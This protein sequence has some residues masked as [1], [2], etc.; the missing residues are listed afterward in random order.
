MHSSIRGARP[1]GFTLIELLVVIAIIGVLISLLVPAVQKV[2]WAAA[3]TQCR[4]NLHNLGLA[5]T[6]YKDING[7][8]YPDAALNG[9]SQIPTST[10]PASP[11]PAGLKYQL[12]DIIGY[13]AENNVQILICPMD[14]QRQA[15]GRSNPNNSYDYRQRACKKTL[16][17]IEYG[18]LRPL[19]LESSQ[20]YIMC[21]M[22]DFHDSAFSPIARNFL[23]L[24]G[25]VGS[26][27]EVDQPTGSPRFSD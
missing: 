17:V 20:I 16:P 6:M 14:T 5:I 24:D 18:G 2:R 25:H 7:G 27:L 4:N 19:N 9:Y 10:Y 8:K 26:S 22:D 3:R 23:Y 11:V 15:P 12:F 21:D 13:Y 1:R